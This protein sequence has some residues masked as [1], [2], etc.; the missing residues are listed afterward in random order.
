M[1]I[2]IYDFKSLIRNFKVR[3]QKGQR[4]QS[5][6]LAS[7]VRCFACSSNYSHSLH[8]ISLQRIRMGYTTWVYFFVIYFNHIWDTCEYLDVIFR[9]TKCQSFQFWLLRHMKQVYTLRAL[10]S[11]VQRNI[12]GSNS[13]YFTCFWRGISVEP[14]HFWLSEFIPATF[15][16]WYVSDSIL[17]VLHIW[18]ALFFMFEGEICDEKSVWMP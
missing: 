7:W 16:L 11:I 10:C 5:Y 12:W 1:A 8:F 4:V 2:R 18:M 13:W 15:T 6:S 17:A 14:L 9:G 3:C